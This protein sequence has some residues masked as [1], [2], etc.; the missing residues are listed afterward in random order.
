[1]QVGPFPNANAVAL[2]ADGG[3]V[4]AGSVDDVFAL[5]GFDSTG[6]VDSRFGIGGLARTTIGVRGGA[7]AVTVQPD[8]RIL[9]GGWSSSQTDTRF[10]LARYLVTTPTTIDGDP[11]VVDYGQRITVRGVLT[12]RGEPGGAVS[13]VRRDC[14]AP[15]ETTG[16]P[17]AVDANGGWALRFR[18]QSRTVFWAKV[19]SERSSPLIVRVRPSVALSRLSPRLLRAR[20]VFVRP[21]A[22]A[23][24]V[25]QSYSPSARHWLD[26]RE[27]TLRRSGRPPTASNATFRLPAGPRRWFRVLLRQTDPDGCFAT[28]SSRAIRR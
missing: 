18:P 10:V 2:K 16:P 8:G 4:V 26:E 6:E 15:A 27:A 11:L 21:L 17:V 24:V 5:T 14:Y 23:L 25:L 3:I 7:N 22:G 12:E 28:A 1:M 20:V 9:V 19:G 13:L